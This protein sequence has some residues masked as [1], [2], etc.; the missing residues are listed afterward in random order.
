MVPVHATVIIFGISF[1]SQQLTI[2]AGT[3]YSIFPGFHSCLS[4]KSSFL[5]DL[6][7]RT[8][9]E[10]SKSF[11]CRNKA[12]C[13]R[14]ETNSR[15]KNQRI[16]VI[17]HTISLHLRIPRLPRRPRHPCELCSLCCALYSRK[18]CLI[19]V[20]AQMCHCFLECTA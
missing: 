14:S 18:Q 9:R 19:F 7:R 16:G 3:G 5:S 17:F 12:I 2:T 10:S 11:S 4:I 1:S 13:F 8:A 20:Q 6:S 15:V